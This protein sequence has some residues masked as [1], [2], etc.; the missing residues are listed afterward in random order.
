MTWLHIIGIGEDG[1]D[2]LTV[3]ARALVESA[4]VIIGGDR[5]HKL[6]P[7]V[8]AE[9]LKW[10][11]PFDAM[12]DEIKRHK[13][14][15]LVILVTGDPLWYSVGA[16]ILRAIPA[17]EI[18]FHPQLS[19][20]QWASTRMGW[21]LADTETLTVHG[22]PAEQVIPYLAP[23]ARLLLLTK[24]EGTPADIARILTSQ[25]Y[26]ASQLTVLGALGGPNESRIDGT[27]ADWEAEAPAF[28]L[29][30]V[31][32][33]ADD[34]ATLIPHGP[35]LPDDAFAHDGKMTK[36][37]V[38]AAT[39]AKL[40]P[41][42]KAMLWD[43]GSGCGSVAIEW[44]RAARDAEAIGLEPNAKR[45]ALAQE[46]AL[47]LGAP[48]LKLIDAKAPEGLADLPTPDAIFIGGG[49]SPAVIAA[50]ITALPRHGRLVANAVTLESEA[51]LIAAHAEHGG[52]LTRIAISRAEPV[53]PFRGWRPLMTVTQWSLVT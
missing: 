37:E 39:L 11:S 19:A 27:A 47:K 48:R 15:R 10:P 24:N 20:F 22:R 53:G 33:L 2:G 29:L 16:R 31:E 36:Q 25:G 12:I 42:R 43:I 49:L 46:N 35:G 8:T 51:I 4:E 52:E 30:A 13:G 14:R 17:D 40:W 18:T 32:V 38:R 50:S 28:H 3:D 7:N 26:G 1:M 6:S 44:M 23:C 34:D 9:R 21:S 45:R 5:H 41:R